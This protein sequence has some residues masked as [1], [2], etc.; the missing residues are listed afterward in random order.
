MSARMILIV[1]DERNIG[2]VL[3]Q[4]LEPLGFRTSVATSGPAAL[5]QLGNAD[6]H[7]MLLDVRMPGMDGLEVLGRVRQSRPD[8]RVIMMTAYGT[9]DLAVQ[10]MKAGATDFIQKPFTPQEVRDLVTKV[11]ATETAQRNEYETLLAQ[12]KKHI[13]DCEFDA[14]AVLL[15]RAMNLDSVRPQA[16]NLMGA[17]LQRKGED[18]EALKFFQAAVGLKAGDEGDKDEENL[19]AGFIY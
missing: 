5:D 7:V 13:A 12:A 10:A 8:I 9:I 18:L 17:V 4:A 14:A 3:S 1:D 6:I 2:L 19:D 16:Y 15:R 11:L